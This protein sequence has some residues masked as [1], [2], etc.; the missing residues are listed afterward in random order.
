MRSWTVHL[1]GW[2]F[3]WLRLELAELTFQFPLQTR[4]LAAIQELL[5]ACRWVLSAPLQAGA[6]LHYREL[7]SITP[8]AGAGDE[9]VFQAGAR[10]LLQLNIGEVLLLNAFEILMGHVGARDAFVIGGQRHR[11]PCANVLAQRVL[12]TTH[13][14]NDIIAGQTDLNHD[15]APGHL[16]Q[17]LKRSC[18]V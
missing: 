17:K 8:Q 14:E 12:R 7:V 1:V 3:P 16:L 4:L 9:G 10:H 6:F 15:V 13:P 2:Y 5:A 18:L 11:H